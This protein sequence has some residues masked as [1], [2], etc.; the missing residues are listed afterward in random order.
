MSASASVWRAVSV[1]RRAKILE[2]RWQKLCAK[3]LPRASKDSIWRLSRNDRR[4]LPRAGWKLHISATI[5]NAPQVLNRVGPFLTAQRVLFKAPRSL[6][7]INEL[8]SGLNS[9]YSQVG[10]I[11]TVYP[12]NDDEAVFLA[13]RLHELT[14]RFSAPNIPFDLKFADTGNV[15]YRYGA[16]E[17]LELTQNGRQLP[18]LQTSS[19]ELIFDDRL[20]SKP[21]WVMDPFEPHK[22]ETRT[23]AAR[24]PIH[25]MKVLVQ[26]GKGG[27]Y[28][29]LDLTSATPQLCLLKQGRKNG[30][31][32][33]DGRDGAWRVRHEGR[34]LSQ[35]S[36]AGV[37]VPRV[38]SS[39]E[40]DGNYYLVME[41]LN[42]ETL[43]D[44][45]ASRARR[46]PIAQVLRCG[47]Q[48]A[49]FMAKLHRAGWVW[50]DCKPRN[51]IVT[52][53]GSLAP[54][55]FEGA[56]P[57]GKPDPMRW[58]TPG[59]KPPAT[60]RGKVEN[61]KAD[62]LYAL[63]SMLFLLVTGRIYNPQKLTSI[64][65]LRSNVPPKLV[66]LIESLL[67]TDPGVRT[68][69]DTVRAT[70][71]SILR[72]LERRKKTLGEKTTPLL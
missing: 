37:T 25:I 13:Q 11:I 38:R 60:H 49:Q 2:A 19:G 46:L 42:G 21:D 8:N 55:D 44:K 69:I 32:S 57:I 63:G 58:G 56:A 5:L 40:L 31:I 64:Q 27:V 59:F 51:I 61:G 20:R 53:N 18:A 71:S 26:R 4:L 1:S 43:H 47:L 10:K 24:I 15:Y 50:R 67:A 17:Y 70:L 30:E 29:G 12:R 6:R 45:L 52:A 9:R 35:L 39:F 28:V 48:L 7:E 41:Y 54:I 36:A 16:F 68:E 22:L 34:V 33:W 3:Y 14:R 66:Q 62:D 23:S 72:G 65:T